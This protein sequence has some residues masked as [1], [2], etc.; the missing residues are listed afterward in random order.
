M[1]K[2][3]LLSCLIFIPSTTQADVI[4]SIR[5]ST[6]KM[7]EAQSAA[8][9]GALIQ[10]A[11]NNGI[12]ASDVQEVTLTPVQFQAAM[13]NLYA[14]DIAT[15]GTQRQTE[16]AATAQTLWNSV[17]LSWGTTAATTYQTALNA[18][19]TQAA[20]DIAALTTIASVKNYQPV[21]PAKTG[22]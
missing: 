4:A 10:N 9:A 18:V 2:L 6:G 7:I 20:T 11:I 14:P 19:K 16:I 3:I 22:L 17:S 21:W 1:K 8:P 13:D 15:A 5:I 12:P